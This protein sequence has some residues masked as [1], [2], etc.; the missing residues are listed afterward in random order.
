MKLF[1]KYW[2]LFL[3]PFFFL[4]ICYIVFDP[5][6]VIWPYDNYYVKGDGGINRD[7][8]STTTYIK[9]KD[10]YH[11]DSFIFGNSRSLFFKIDDWK[12]YINP[13]SMCYHYSESGGSVIGLLKKL[14]LID[15]YNEKINNAIIALDY[16][17]LYQ[18]EGK[19]RLFSTAPQLL[20]YRNFF[21]FHLEHLQAWFDFNFLKYWTYYHV[22]NIET[23]K[24]AKYIEKGN[25]YDYYNPITNEEPFTEEDI[26]MNKGLF[27]DESR[28]NYFKNIQHP[29]S[30][31]PIAINDERKKILTQAKNILI[32]HNTIYKIVINPLYNQIKI[33]PQDYNC[34]CEIFGKD[35]V[36]DFTG[37][38]KWT[39]DYHNYYEPS[40]Y[41]PRVA[42]EIMDSIYKKPNNTF[43]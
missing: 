31:F 7:Y 12:K 2:L 37:I 29:D 43:H 36:F 11:Y 15:K 27:Y 18:T 42:L 9:Q 13:N 21:R 25:N 35:N 4:L 14:E 23:P 24:M 30:I 22:F 1:I 3:I 5:F 6:K 34:L 41:I 10:T 39:S 33:N 28:M 40:H 20:S 17:I 19:E 8:V 32:K 16:D 26:L 38:N